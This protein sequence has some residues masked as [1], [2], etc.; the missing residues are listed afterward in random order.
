MSQ[1]YA[2]IGLLVILGFAFLEIA[3]LKLTMKNFTFNSKRWIS[4]LSIGIGERFTDLF[5]APY[6]YLFFQFLYNHYRFFTIPINWWS[7]ILLLIVT[8]FIWYWYHRSSHRV[9]IFW[10]AHIVHHQS[11]DYNL[12]V[13]ARITLLQTFIRTAFYSILPILGFSANE[14][15]AILLI[16]GIYS[17]FTHTQ[18][19]KKLHFLE[20]VFITPSLHGVHHA[21]NTEYIDKN[22][23]DI[24]VFWDKLFGTFVKEGET[25]KY[26]LV[27]PFESYSF[28]WQH[29]HYFTE[30]F[31]ALKSENIKLKQLKIIFGPPENLDKMYNPIIEAKF[32]QSANNDTPIHL[33]CYIIIQTLAS[34]LILLGSIWFYPLITKKIAIALFTLLFLSLINIGAI[35]EQKKYIPYLEIVRLIV[36][37]F[38]I[39]C[40]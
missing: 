40:F 22:Y 34:L 32:V 13:A 25:P 9:N 26:G 15:F 37:I 3:I 6:V 14:I 19:G 27:K 4:N 28:L 21:S 18:I 38:L 29:F 5:F 1:K 2:V 39:S 36:L 35:M 33:K 10:A 23:G 8:D 31:Y 12:T 20:S 30:L 24:F 7:L 17:F 11:S 16:H